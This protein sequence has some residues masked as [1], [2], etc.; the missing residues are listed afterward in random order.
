M[1]TVEAEACLDQI[2]MLVEIV[3]MISFMEFH[4]GKSSLIIH[5]RFANRN[6]SMGI[7]LFDVAYITLTQQGRTLKRSQSTSKTN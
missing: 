1:E 4:K 6:T 3:P 2:H 7:D 5:E